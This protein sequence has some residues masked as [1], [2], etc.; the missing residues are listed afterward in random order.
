VA[1]PSDAYERGYAAGQESAERDIALAERVARSVVAAI[2][3]QTPAPIIIE[4]PAPQPAVAMPYGVPP[5]SAYGYPYGYGY[6]AAYPPYPFLTFGF[7]GP[8]LTAAR[9]FSPH[10]HH[11]FGRSSGPARVGFHH[12]GFGR[13]R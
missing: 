4:T 13:M 1:A 6:P 2:P 3:Q 10:A 9:V 7:R 12:R 11:H 5:F 8:V